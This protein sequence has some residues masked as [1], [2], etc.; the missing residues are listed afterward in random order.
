ME[1]IKEY[2]FSSVVAQSY[3]KNKLSGTWVAQLVECLTLDFSLGHGLRVMELSPILGSLLS[4]ESAC[5]S[6]SAPPPALSPPLSP[7]FNHSLSQ[8]NK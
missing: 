1:C 2:K 4:E 3:T 8:I 6:P 7:S 5:A